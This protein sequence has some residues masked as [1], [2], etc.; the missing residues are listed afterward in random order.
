MKRNLLQH[1]C[2]QHSLYK[3]MLPQLNRNQLDMMCKTKNPW[4]QC[5]Y[6]QN[7]KYMMLHLW[8][9]KFPDHRMCMTTNQLM[10]NKFQ[11]HMTCKKKPRHLSKYQHHMTHMM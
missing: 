6:R 2:Q 7:M 3:K 5:M 11:L 1:M 9:N 10:M 4:Y 8:K